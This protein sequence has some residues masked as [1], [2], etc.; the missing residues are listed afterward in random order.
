[1]K[2]NAN[3]ALRWCKRAALVWML[4]MVLLT[5]AFVTYVLP[6]PPPSAPSGAAVQVKSGFDSRLSWYVHSGQWRADARTL[7][8]LV[9]YLVSPEPTPLTNQ[10]TVR[11]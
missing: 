1:M 2:T 5:P 3:V 9:R 4:L 8:A 11:A 10:P 6:S 7:A